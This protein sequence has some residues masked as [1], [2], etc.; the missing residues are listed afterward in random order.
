[1]SQYHDF[2]NK[3]DWEKIVLEKIRANPEKFP[4]DDLSMKYLWWC[5]Y[6]VAGLTALGFDIFCHAGIKF[7]KN[8]C[9]VKRW[10]ARL[11][12]GLARMP[13][14]FYW[15]QVKNHHIYCLYLESEECSML[16]N[17]VDNDIISLVG[18]FV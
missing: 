17:M 16:L 9:E 12:L 8:D 18:K 2:R 13:Y 3:A 1:M 5:P 14:L 4:D 11:I 10:N 15:H 6:Q 7:T